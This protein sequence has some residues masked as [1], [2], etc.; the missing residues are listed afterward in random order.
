MSKK[1][2]LKFCDYVTT[3]TGLRLNW[4]I[5]ELCLLCHTLAVYFSPS[6]CVLKLVSLDVH[7]EVLLK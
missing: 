4:T 6:M 2:P 5:F 1:M 7:L 3:Y